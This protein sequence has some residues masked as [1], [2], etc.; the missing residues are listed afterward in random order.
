LKCAVDRLVVPNLTLKFVHAVRF[1]KPSR[2]LP[3]SHKLP[4]LFLIFRL[5]KRLVIEP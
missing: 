4:T 5:A 3:N 1:Q 2:G